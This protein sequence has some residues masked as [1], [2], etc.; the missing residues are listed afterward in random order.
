MGVFSTQFG[1]KNNVRT[2]QSTLKTT[3]DHKWFKVVSIKIS[4]EHVDFWAKTLL[5]R[6]H[7]L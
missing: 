7:H 5:F 1:A 2:I 6:T 4:F 3:E